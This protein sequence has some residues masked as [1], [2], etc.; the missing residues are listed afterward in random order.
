MSG[1]TCGALSTEPSTVFA[2]VPE[3]L[4]RRIAAAAVMGLSADG[5]FW[6]D[7]SGRRLHLKVQTRTHERQGDSTRGI[8]TPM[9]LESG[10]SADGSWWEAITFIKGKERPC[11]THAR[12]YNLGVVLSQWHRMVPRSGLRLDDPSG[13]ET[14]LGTARRFYPAA[15]PALAKAAAHA[16]PGL[17]MV[18]IHGDV[19][20]THNSLWDG[21]CI[22]GLIDP[23][24][25]AVGPAALDLA[26]AATHD[27]ATS[28]HDTRQALLAGYGGEPAGWAG[29][30]QVTAART[31]LDCAVEGDTKGQQRIKPWLGNDLSK[32]LLVGT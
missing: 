10:T 7:S 8:L 13:L 25:V 32:A 21:D 12:A 6:R 30:L 29:A 9:L 31:W 16:F 14:W 27:I 4:E 28:G 15:F 17:A 20:V 23:G 3:P 5:Q 24:T 26:F 18:G 22:T 19:A 11:P 2:G 1:D